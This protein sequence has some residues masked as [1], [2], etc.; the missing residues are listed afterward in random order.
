MRV[1]AYQFINR[2]HSRRGGEVERSKDDFF[3]FLE[4]CV[5]SE[6]FIS[7]LVL[8]PVERRFRFSRFFFRASSASSPRSVLRVWPIHT[9]VPAIEPVLALSP[10]LNSS[11]A[12]PTRVLPT[13][14]AAPLGTYVYTSIYAI[15]VNRS[16]Y[17]E[18]RASRSLSRVHRYISVPAL[19]PPTLA[20]C[21]RCRYFDQRYRGAFAH[22]AADILSSISRLWLIHAIL[23]A[24][25]T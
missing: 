4:L 19:A 7:S 11:L 14:R 22:S 1:H 6:I 21:C 9:C 15:T 20:C 23:L 5:L 25:I 13:R 16:E 17:R 12:R 10:T 2:K 18:P 3:G 8:L 24:I